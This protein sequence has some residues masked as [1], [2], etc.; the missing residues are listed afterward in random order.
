MHTSTL[1]SPFLAQKSHQNT[2][3]SATLDFSLV[4]PWFS[5]FSLTLCTVVSK[6]PRFL[7][8]AILFSWLLKTK[9]QLGF[10][11]LFYI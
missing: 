5:A 4:F 3:F 8:L 11:G 7:V 6:K 9:Q 10:L 1:H 2:W